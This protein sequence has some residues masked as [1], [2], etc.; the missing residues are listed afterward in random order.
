MLLQESSDRNKN[1]REKKRKREEGRKREKHKENEAPI[2]L[3][4]EQDL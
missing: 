4:G 3:A 1:L 2:E